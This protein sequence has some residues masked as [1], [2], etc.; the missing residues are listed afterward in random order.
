MTPS[1]QAS[2]AVRAALQ[3]FQDGYSRRESSALDTF[4]ELFTSD[5]ELEV[6]GTSAVST[7]TGEWCIG[8]PAVRSLIEADW[9]SWGDLVLDV[10][11]ARIYAQGA[12]AWLAT[13]GTVTQTIPLAQTY[14]NITAYLARV[15][16][17]R[18]DLD[19]E[20][21]L[22]MVI[23]GAASTLA[24]ARDGERYMWPMRFTAVLVQQPAGW[25]FHQVHF[26]YATIHDPDV[27]VT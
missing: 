4:M 9:Q 21:E 25:Q 13:T 5:S 10:A 3:A 2:A 23:L 20:R 8:R 16:E 19:I 6:I 24:S 15:I 1:T 17:Q 12:V 18:A 27:R 7:A 26:S 22:L 11:G 14:G